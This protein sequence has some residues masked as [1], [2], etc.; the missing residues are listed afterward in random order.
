[1]KRPCLFQKTRNLLESVSENLKKTSIEE[2]LFLVKHV[3]VFTKLE[4]PETPEKVTKLVYL[5]SC[6]LRV[7]VLIFH[8]TSAFSYSY[9]AEFKLHQ[10][11]I[12][13]HSPESLQG[14][15]H[16]APTA[17]NN[18]VDNTRTKNNTHPA[19]ELQPHA[20][21]RYFYLYGIRASF[22]IV[23]TWPLTR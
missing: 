14:K 13:L 17:I 7:T 8:I 3:F 22:I 5:A 10:A 6:L 2:L 20:Q 23:T 18:D 16:H 4:E 9:K 15:N 19:N 1:M 21:N 12:A 11:K